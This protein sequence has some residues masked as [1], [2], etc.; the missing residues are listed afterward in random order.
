MA[1]DRIM[2]MCAYG[3]GCICARV[4]ELWVTWS[5]GWTGRFTGADRY[6]VIE[7]LVFEMTM[8]YLSGSSSQQ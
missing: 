2:C 7:R 3:C 6:G 8:I 5:D 4:C 1:F